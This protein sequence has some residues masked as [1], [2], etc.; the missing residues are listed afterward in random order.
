MHADGQPTTD[1]ELEINLGAHL[2]PL[3]LKRYEKSEEERSNHGLI[4]S[5][6]LYGTKECEVD[7][8]T[9]LMKGLKGT[10]IGRAHV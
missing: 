5:N 6:G 7:R 3:R 8:R 4:L 1:F 9:K 10:K 2:P